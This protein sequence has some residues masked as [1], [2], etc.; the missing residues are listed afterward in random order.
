[1]LLKRYTL[2]LIVLTMLLIG[3]SAFAQV[4][5][6]D[7]VL[8]IYPEN[9]N[10]N[11]NI[12]ATLNSHAID[13]DKANIYWSL[14][15]E[16]VGGGVGK[17]TFSFK[18]GSLGSS[19]VLSATID[20]VDGQSMLKTATISPTNVDILWEAYDVY[21]PPFYK[22]KTLVGSQGSFKVVAIPNIVY[23]G[24]MVSPNN[25]SYTWSKDGSVKTDSSGWG[26]N[27]LIFQNSY[28]DKDNNIEVK[29]SDIAGGITAS[30]KLNLKTTT[31]KIVFY[32]NDRNLGMVWEKSI[33]DGFTI[34]KE[35]STLVAE[36]YFFSP[37]NLNSSSL[38]FDWYING[39]KIPTQL[40][41]NIL[42]IAPEAG[43]SGT[44]TIK[45][46]VNNINTLFQSAEQK[47]NVQF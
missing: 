20:T 10:P 38:S 3:S 42:P 12:T 24:S 27:H 34:E 29:V 5:A 6:T 41:K 30:G 45:L 15:N 11:Q 17:K 43:K 4:R 39:D 28:L 44:A 32:K 16:E 13:L 2:S 19:S 22:G 18:T 47:L 40:T 25:L 9:P 36:P 8:S 14:N 26:K 21:S 31:P 33:S 7:I 35:G 46:L 1:M 23:Q 37:K